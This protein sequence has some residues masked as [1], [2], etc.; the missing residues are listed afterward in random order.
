MLPEM[1][2]QTALHNYYSIPTAIPKQGKKGHGAHEVQSRTHGKRRR[3]EEVSRSISNESKHHLL[4]FN[5]RQWT[6]V[7]LSDISAKHPSEEMFRFTIEKVMSLNLEELGEEH[8]LLWIQD[9]N[10]IKTTSELKKNH[11]IHPAKLIRQ[12]DDVN[13]AIKSDD[14]SPRGIRGSST[15]RFSSMNCEYAWL[16]NFFQTLIYDQEYKIIYPHVEAGYVAFKARKGERT[17]EEIASL[18]HTLNPK[19][20]KQQGSDLWVRS[21]PEDNKNAVAEMSRLV[22]LKF[23]QN[24]LLADWLQQTPPPFEE[25]TNDDFWGSAMGTATGPRSNKLGKILERVRNLLM[26]SDTKTALDFS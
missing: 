17:E 24:S 5:G 19:E 25:F 9:F 6:L 11:I 2:F 12:N 20:V 16:S 21:S 7:D 4:M 8:L 15:V 3:I 26:V 10:R 1:S 22:F 18:A 23:Q 14:G 13:E